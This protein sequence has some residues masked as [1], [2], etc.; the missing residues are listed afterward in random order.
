MNFLIRT[1]C[2][3][4]EWK[5]DSNQTKFVGF[6][7][8]KLITQNAFQFGVL[9]AMTVKL[10]PMAVTDNSVSIYSLFLYYIDTF[11]YIIYVNIQC[12]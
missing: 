1:S 5:C 6:K 11:L 7:L 3:I 2:R 10:T 4:L 8:I 9:P 12:H